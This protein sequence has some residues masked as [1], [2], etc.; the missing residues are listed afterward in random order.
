[1]NDKE[2][3]P[4]YASTQWYISIDWFDAN[5]RSA[6]MMIKEYL[7]PKCADELEHKKKPGSPEDLI[8]RIQKCCSNAPGFINQRIPI[9]ESV[10][11]L[12]LS[13]GNAPLYLEEIGRQLSQLR[14][15]DAYRTSPEALYRLLQDDRYYGLQEITG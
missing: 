13:G 11:R 9:M 8:A 4:E 15:G 10:F 5:N 1:L 12:F 2:E 14:E 6:M 7:C 3:I